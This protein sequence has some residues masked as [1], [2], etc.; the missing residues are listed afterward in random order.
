MVNL[1]AQLAHCCTTR[2]TIT[3]LWCLRFKSQLHSPLSYPSTDLPRKGEKCDP[4]HLNTTSGLPSWRWHPSPHFATPQAQTWC[5]HSAPSSPKL[6]A[7]KPESKMERIE[8]LRR[9]S[10]QVNIPIIY[11]VILIFRVWVFQI[12]IIMKD[13]MVLSA[14]SDSHI[15]SGLQ[16]ALR[17]VCKPCEQFSHD[18][19]LHHTEC[20][21]LG[22]SSLWG[23]YIQVDDHVYSYNLSSSIMWF[24]EAQKCRRMQTLILLNHVY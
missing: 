16:L 21:W 23:T 7:S 10:K 3:L 1:T 5:L 19:C 24:R 12:P 13:D 8:G 22:A 18:F 11:S 14:P 15:K 2:T 9:A 20:P 17:W 4:C 6:R